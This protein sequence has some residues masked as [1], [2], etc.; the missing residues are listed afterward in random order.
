M[1]YLEFTPTSNL[2]AFS[3]AQEMRITLDCIARRCGGG[4]QGTKG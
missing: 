4:A 1:K 3:L 2:A